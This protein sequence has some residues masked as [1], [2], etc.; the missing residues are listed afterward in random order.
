MITA[1]ELLE[2][3][4][5]QPGGLVIATLPVPPLP[6]KVALDGEMEKVQAALFW[7]TVTMTPPTFRCPVRPVLGFAAIESG[8]V[9]VQNFVI[10][11]TEIQGTSVVTSNGQSVAIATSRF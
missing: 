7:V 11:P 5:E 4:H 2:A 6:G 9:R 10:V 1:D 8:T 3:D